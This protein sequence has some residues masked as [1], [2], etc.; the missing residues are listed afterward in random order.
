VPATKPWKPGC[1]KPVSGNEESVIGAWLVV[2][3]AS[4]TYVSLYLI[5][6]VGTHRGSD[7][8]DNV[9]IV[10][11]LYECGIESLKNEI[12]KS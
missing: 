4:A 2:P 11:A 7:I 8:T 9:K 10:F 1:Y 6:F 12:F 5:L 3:C